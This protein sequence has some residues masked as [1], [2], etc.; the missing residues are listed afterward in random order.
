[1]HSGGWWTGTFPSRSTLDLRTLL[2]DMCFNHANCLGLISTLLSEKLKDNKS[3]CLNKSHLAE[4]L[5][6]NTLPDL[7]WNHW[8]YAQSQFVWT[9]ILDLLVVS[10][11][12]RINHWFLQI[13][14]RWSKR[15]CF[16]KLW[17]CFQNEYWV[18][19]ALQ[20]RCW[21]TLHNFRSDDVVRQ[22]CWLAFTFSAAH[23]RALLRDANSK[24][25]AA[26]FL[27]LF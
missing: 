8:L 2:A 6:A 25:A 26:K 3:G 24:S 4:I 13:E 15:Q 7:R 20:R 12:N 14:T 11:S 17:T 9:Q 10:W 27:N 23:R 18:E 5:T 16:V 21:N 22:H 1:M 19:Q